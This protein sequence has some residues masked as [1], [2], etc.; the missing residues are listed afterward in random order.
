MNKWST[1]R[2]LLAVLGIVLLIG[3]IITTILIVQ[4]RQDGRVKAEKSTT[5]SLTPAT[6]T[7]QKDGAASLDLNIDPGKNQVNLVKVTL[8]FD[9][10]RFSVTATDFTLES[11]SNLT[12]INGPVPGEGTFAV[13]IGTGSDPTKVIRGPQ[14][15][16]NLKLKAKTTA[17]TGSSDVSFD[18]EQTEVRSIGSDDA[19]NENVLSSATPATITIEAVC[20]PNISTCSWDPLDG[21][22]N[23]KFKVIDTSSNSVFKEGIVPDTSV[24][25]TSTPGKTYRCEVIAVND[26]AGEGEAGVGTTTCALPSQSP[27]PT[28]PGNTSTPTPTPTNGPSST[29]TPT[30]PRSSVTPTP[31]TPGVTSTPTPTTPQGGVESPTPT[32]PLDI[33]AVPSLPPTGNPMVLGGV[34]G[35]LLIIIGGIALL[36]L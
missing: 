16:G 26:C 7:V 14:K 15:L 36:I 32:T 17:V 22:V 35:A 2:K 4:K 25:F 5:L 29:P 33:S 3:G 8:K 13:V 12:I 27:T 1:N 20:R 9:A 11:G 28:T 18:Y 21:A 34:V 30:T 31:T 23:Y 10:A 24:E 6:Q 19:F